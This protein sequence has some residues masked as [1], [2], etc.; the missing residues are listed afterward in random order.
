MTKVAWT[1]VFSNS[2]ETSGCKWE[3]VKSNPLFKQF[4]FVNHLS[5]AHTEQGCFMTFCVRPKLLR[6]CTLLK[7]AK[8][9]SVAWYL[10]A[11][12]RV[13]RTTP[14]G[15]FESVMCAGETA[16]RRLHSRPENFQEPRSCY[17]ISRTTK[18][19]PVLRSPQQTLSLISPS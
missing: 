13:S 5:F 8:M 11:T 2:R 6:Q 10:I 9:S 18:Y 3:H 14:A 19:T 1:S 15:V 17:K 16:L 4:S 7:F 12:R